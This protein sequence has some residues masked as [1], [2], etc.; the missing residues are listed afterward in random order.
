MTTGR[1][2]PDWIDKRS[3]SRLQLPLSGSCSIGGPPEIAC[4]TISVSTAGM[5]VR[6]GERPEPGR[7]ISG[8]FDDIGTISG[9]VV[10]HVEDGF[11]VAFDHGA[12]RRWE[13]V[14]TLDWLETAHER[15]LR[16]HRHAVRR[17]APPI[18]I[19][20]VLPDR[21]RVKVRVTDASEIGAR[22]VTDERPVI[23]ASIALGPLTARIVRHTRDGVGVAFVR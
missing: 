15:K 14:H 11:A 6:S 1:Y 21:R 20:M 23:G 5:T 16:N 10:R 19:D 22:L 9:V 12:D 3:D 2:R 17:G 4:T 7:G 8:R 13:L 18:A